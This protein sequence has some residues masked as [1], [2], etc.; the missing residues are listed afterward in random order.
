M[1]SAPSGSAHSFGEGPPLLQ[2]TQQGDRGSERELQPCFDT[3]R[4]LWEGF[5]AAETEAKG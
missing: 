1:A 3:Y 5:C 2:F 4:E